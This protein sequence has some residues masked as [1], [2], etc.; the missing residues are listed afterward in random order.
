MITAEYLVDFMPQILQ[1]NLPALSPTNNNR[2]E[3]FNERDLLYKV[4]FDLRKEMGGLKDLVGKLV[5]YNDLSMP[6]DM[7]NYPSI[8]LPSSTI[9]NQSTNYNRLILNE[10]VNNNNVGA[11]TDSSIRPIILGNSQNDATFDSMEVVEETLSLA[12]MEKEMIKKALKKYKGRRK[13]A[14]NELEI[15]ER[16]LYRK[17]KEYEL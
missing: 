11:N 5:K 13:D 9:P 17:I 7:E 1:R 2:S 8:A 16:T 10:E 3:D 6:E 15:S 14:A 12:A 4:L